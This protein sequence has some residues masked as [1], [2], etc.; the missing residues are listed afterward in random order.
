MSYI[1]ETDS[2]YS[3]LQNFDEIKSSEQYE[4]FYN[5][6]GCRKLG[7]RYTCVS[8]ETKTIFLNYHNMEKLKFI[9]LG[10]VKE[11]FLNKLGAE[12]YI[13]DFGFHK[14]SNVKV[15]IA[16]PSTLPK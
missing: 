11:G 2:I 8:G 5:A 1:D 6:V 14:V 10:Y 12:D 13:N 7:V 16:V 3:F 9:A 4:K 15:F